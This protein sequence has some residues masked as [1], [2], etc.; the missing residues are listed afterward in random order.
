MGVRYVPQDRRTDASSG[1]EHAVVA[2]LDGAKL[3]QE[4]GAVATGFVC[5]ARR[6]RMVHLPIRVPKMKWSTA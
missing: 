1:W 2:S 3:P 5:R 6:A 4:H